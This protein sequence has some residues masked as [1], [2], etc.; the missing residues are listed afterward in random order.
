MREDIFD[1]ARGQLVSPEERAE[2][3]SAL[4]SVGAGIVRREAELGIDPIAYNYGYPP[5]A[6]EHMIDSNPD[7]DAMV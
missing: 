5:D 4:E 6:D 7:P 3:A 1:E 2:I